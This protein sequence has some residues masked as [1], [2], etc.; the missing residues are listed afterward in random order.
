MAKATNIAFGDPVAIKI[1]AAE[2]FAV[3]MQR[4]STLNRL[5]APMPPKGTG[6]AEATLREQTSK[7]MPIVRRRDL[8]KGKG[9]EV[10]FHL[11]NPEKLKERVMVCVNQTR[12]SRESPILN[13]VELKPIVR[14]RMDKYGDQ[15]LLVHM[16]GARGFHKTWNGNCRSMA[17]LNLM[18]LWGIRFSLPPRTGTISP[19]DPASSHSE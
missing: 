15:S 17:T 18:T 6:E 12:F 16:C 5:S 10:E 9:D 3:H 4:D 19:P 2:D 13:P 14:A 7:H 11:I 8:R 1:Q